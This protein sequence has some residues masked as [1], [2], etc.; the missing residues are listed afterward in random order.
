[1][2]PRGA[3]LRKNRDFQAVYR[4]R[5]SWATPHLVLYVRTRSV[6]APESRFRIRLGFVIS[7]KVAKRSHV[8]NRLK[9]RLREIGRHRL[10]STIP[11]DRDWDALFVA[12]ASATA[13]TF[14][15]LDQDVQALSRQAGLM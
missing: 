12:R 2:L 7:T 8:R 9:R 14:A 11:A 6:G 15:E 1:M 4:A 5:K 13:L 10:L 3:R